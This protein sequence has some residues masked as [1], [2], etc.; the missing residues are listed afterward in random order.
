MNTGN[1]PQLPLASAA[2]SCCGPAQAARPGAALPE[3]SAHAS[4]AAVVRSDAD[5]APQRDF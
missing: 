3:P 4:P 2:C 1:R 5:A